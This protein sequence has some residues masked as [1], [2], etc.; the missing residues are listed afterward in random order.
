MYENLR[1]CS[2]NRLQNLSDEYI[3]DKLRSVDEDWYKTWLKEFID[4]NMPYKQYLNKHRTL[5]NHIKV[6]LDIDQL[7]GYLDERQSLS[8]LPYKLCCRLRA[9]GYYLLKDLQY[10]DETIVTQDERGIV[11]SALELKYVR[12]NVLY[13]DTGNKYILEHKCGGYVS[14]TGRLVS[15]IRDAYL[16]KNEDTARKAL[17]TGYRRDYQYLAIKEVNL[18]VI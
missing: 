11:E 6:I 2:V 9:N 16:Y 15:D 12:D 4:L 17:L 3:T 5:Y 14:S 7:L 8:F 13:A 10:L 18:E 1:D